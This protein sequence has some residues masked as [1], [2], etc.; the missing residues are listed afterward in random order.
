M[1]KRALASAAVILV[2]LGAWLVRGGRE[3]PEPSAP[4]VASGEEPAPRALEPPSPPPEAAERAGSDARTP[5]EPP[6]DG[7][8]VAEG[9]SRIHMVI[10]DLADVPV[11]GARV[12]TFEDSEPAVRETSADG[13]ATLPVAPSASRRDSMRLAIDAEGF[14]HV[15]VYY[16]RLPDLHVRLSRAVTLSGRVLDAS[17]GAPVAGARVLG[18]HE[19]CKFDC[20]PPQ[21]LSDDEGR[22]AIDG[23]PSERKTH[24]LVSA[25][26]YADRFFAFELP[27]DPKGVVHDLELERGVLVTGRVVAKENG[28]PIPDVL[29][30]DGYGKKSH[31]D[32]GGTFQH[33]LLPSDGEIELRFFAAGRCSAW[34]KWKP[35]DVTSPVLVELPASAPVR[36]IVTDP[37]GNP[38]AGARVR[39]DRDYRAESRRRTEGKPPSPLDDYPPSW[40]IEEEGYF[41]SGTTDADGRFETGGVVPW[42]RAYRARVTCDGYRTSEEPIAVTESGGWIEVALQPVLDRSRGAGEI[43]GRLTLNGEPVAGYVSWTGGARSGGEDVDVRGDFRLTDVEPGRVRLR[44]WLEEDGYNRFLGGAG[45]VE[46]AV[47]TGE[48]VRHDFDLHVD[49][50]PITGHLLRSDGAPAPGIA[51][52]AVT[53]EDRF[54]CQ[55]DA[56]GAYSVGVPAGTLCDLLVWRA[57]E[58]VSR[59]GVLAGSSGVDLVLPAL[60]ELRFRALDAETRACLSSYDVWWRRPEETRFDSGGVTDWEGRDEHGWYDIDVAAGTIDLLF[61][62]DEQ[63]YQ[64]V[65]RDGVVVHQGQSTEVEVVMRKGLRAEFRLAEEAEFPKGHTVLFLEADAWAGVRH[66]TEHGGNTWDGGERY[67]GPTLFSRAVH[68]E[69]GRATVQGLAPGLHRFKIFPED[70]VIE[71]AEVRLGPEAS[72]EPIQLRWRRGE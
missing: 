39:V 28:S 25:E 66:W 7:P 32:D 15:R 45:E 53:Q 58:S 37:E 61:R 70:L 17:T 12:Q 4:A 10:T 56:E 2:L 71:P 14:V 18:I 6:P 5:A 21:A 62:A 9:P 63:G 34:C 59:K 22:Y 35:E 3:G 41:S 36:G 47:G 72:T 31:G 20:E 55:S 33:R 42:D 60:G 29:V 50:A 13:R 54:D 49:L 19:T 16:M 57:H 40:R 11:A 23:V 67:P 65:Q 51:L 64:P 38:I 68:F 24:V 43:A 52:M 27:A 48:E 46:V 1:K 69:N 30:Q 26:G 44:V 8:V